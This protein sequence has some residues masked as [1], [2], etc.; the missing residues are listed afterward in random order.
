MKSITS[1]KTGKNQIVT[2]ETWASIIE[3][4][5]DK[6][7]IMTTM[8]ERKLTEVPII[9]KPEEVKTKTKPKK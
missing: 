1:I 3:R 5:W 6:R 2:D 9:N 8:I 4:G 7:F